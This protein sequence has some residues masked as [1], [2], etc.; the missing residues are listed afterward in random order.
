[1]IHR[2]F[3]ISNILLWSYDSSILLNE[4]YITLKLSRYHEFARREGG[5]MAK[6]EDENGNII[7][8]KLL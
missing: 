5:I 6:A 7:R 4:Q 8:G 2:Y 3:L 1:M